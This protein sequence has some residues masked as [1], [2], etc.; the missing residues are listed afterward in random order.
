[1][2]WGYGGVGII[3]SLLV[4]LVHNAVY[5]QWGYGGL[6]MANS[7]PVILVRHGLPRLRLEQERALE[8]D[9]VGVVGDHPAVSK[10][11]N[12]YILVNT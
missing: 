10:V 3:D 5:V 1:M 4:E 7:L 9:G 12:P 6:A 2:R 8:A 11:V